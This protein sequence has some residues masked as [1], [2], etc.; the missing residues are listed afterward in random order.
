MKTKAVNKRQTATE[1]P[2]SSGE[3]ANHA[4][5]RPMIPLQEAQC[6]GTAK[7]FVHLSDDSNNKLVREPDAAVVVD[8]EL[9]GETVVPH[10][11]VPIEGG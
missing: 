2:S 10:K 5:E 11:Q 7:E 8:D 6:S 3:N 1:T 9:E 4:D